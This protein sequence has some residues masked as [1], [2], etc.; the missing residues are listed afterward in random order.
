[1]DLLIRPVLKDI[2]VIAHI[3][4]L[5]NVSISVLLITKNNFMILYFIDLLPRIDVWD[6][7]IKKKFPNSPL[8]ICK[9]NATLLPHFPQPTKIN[10]YQSDSISFVLIFTYSIMRKIGHILYF[11]SHLFFIFCQLT[12]QIFDYFPLLICMS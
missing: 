5:K 6:H 4:L 7:S 3:L 2:Q 8:K 11:I 12:I 1:M 9:I 10:L